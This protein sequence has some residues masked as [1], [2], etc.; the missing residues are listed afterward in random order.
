MNPD[1]YLCTVSEGGHLHIRMEA[2]KGRGYVNAEH[3]KHEDANRCT[4]N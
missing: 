4:A 3:N 2:E 1:L